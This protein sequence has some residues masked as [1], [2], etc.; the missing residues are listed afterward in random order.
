MTSK[1][2]SNI[3]KY[4]IASVL[5][6]FGFFYNA[7]QTLYFRSFNLSFTQIGL[8]VTIGMVVTLIT[9]IPTGVIA[10][11]FGNKISV[12]LSTLCN[13]VGTTLVAF[14]SSFNIFAIGF[15]FW[16]LHRTFNSGASTSWLYKSLEMLDNSQDFIKHKGQLS[17]SFISIDIIS[18]L[19][20]PLF[21]A[22]SYRLPYYIS[23]I[24]LLMAFIIQITMYEEPKINFTSNIK[25]N[26]FKQI[27]FD[28]KNSIKSEI[29]VWLTIFT[30]VFFLIGKFFTE[31][32]NEPFLIEIQKI[33]LT[34]LSILGL[35]ASTIQT[36]S[37]FFA[38]K[39]EDR[40][41]DFGSFLL[42]IFGIPIILLLITQT[43]QYIILGVLFGVYYSLGSYVEVV[44]ESYLIHNIKETNRATILSISSMFS[45]LF[46]LVLIPILG[47]ITDASSSKV[48]IF[49]IAGLGFIAGLTLILNYR[50]TS[51]KG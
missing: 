46:S 48:G 38:S 19:L 37:V 50:T 14:G 25:F 40:L 5:G 10:D 29:F 9:E 47:N 51:Y 44:T 23:C 16:G 49:L 12:L 45:S 42:I 21:F 11:R 20:G 36:I 7:I 26:F 22:I 4:Y 43:T 2:K 34:Q 13:M 27:A 1:Y 41:K 18:G 39:V 24:S 15:V 6:G 17:S 31:V 8:L 30:A 32:L 28:I 33:S 35:I 3:W